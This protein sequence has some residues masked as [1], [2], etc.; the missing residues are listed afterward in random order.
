MEGKHLVILFLVLAV[1]I[2]GAVTAANVDPVPAA[3]ARAQAGIAAAPVTASPTGV[4]ISGLWKVLGGLV[5]ILLIAGLGYLIWERVQMRRSGGW[6]SGPYAR[7][8]RAP[9]TKQPTLV[10]LLT[11]QAFQQMKQQTPP[12]YDLPAEREKARF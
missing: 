12:S 3:L 2:V 9:Q 8:Q 11:I 6:V 7:W 10:D 4:A 5:G 1:V